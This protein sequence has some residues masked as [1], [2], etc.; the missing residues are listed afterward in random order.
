MSPKRRI[1][2]AFCAIFAMTLSAHAQTSVYR[3]MAAV[4]NFNDT[5]T[6]PNL[7]LV[8]N[9][10]WQGEFYFDAMSNRLKFAASNDF[11][12]EANQSPNFS[13]PVTGTA[14]RAG[15]DIIVTNTPP[16]LYRIT[17]NDSNLEYRVELLYAS[18][19]NMILNPS[20]EIQHGTRPD[21]AENWARDG[22]ARRSG[23]QSHSGSWKATIESSVSFWASQNSGA[24]PELTYQGSAWFW[25]D[26]TWTSSLI[27]LKIEFIGSGG[28]KVGEARTNFANV[29]GRWVKRTLRAVAP[30]GTVNVHLTVICEDPIPETLRFDDAE[31]RFI[32]TRNQDFDQWKYLYNFA[33]DGAHAWDDWMISTGKV[34]EDELR[35]LTASAS[36]PYSAGSTNFIRSALLTEGLG[37]ISF[38]YRHGATN[39]V[40]TA[41]VSFI[42]QKS[43]DN[44][45][46]TTLG[47]VT[48]IWTATYLQ[49]QSYQYDPTS[50]YVRIVHYGESTNRLL[51]DNI[52]IALP[53]AARRDQDF[54]NWSDWTNNSCYATGNWELCIGRINSVDSLNGKAAEIDYMPAG[55]NFL[56]S[57]QFNGI[58]T[59]SFWYRSGTNGASPV[60]FTL[61]ISTN[62]TVWETIDTVT[63]VSN[64]NYKYHSKYL[65]DTRNL[66]ARIRHD[67]GTNTLLIDNVYIA[68]PQLF[69]YQNFDT[70]PTENSY[71]TYQFQGWTVSNGLIDSEKAYKGK[72][73][74]LNF[75]PEI[76]QYIQSPYLPEGI[77][78]VRFYYSLWNTPTNVYYDIQLSQNG[79]TWTTNETIIVTSTNYTLYE[80][81]LYETNNHYVR[82]YHRS[83]EER[84]LFDEISVAELAPPADVTMY[85]AWHD[86]NPVFTNNSVKIWA[87]AYPWFGATGL[88]LT[89][90]YRIGTDGA[91][92][93]SSG[94]GLTDWYTYAMT[95]PIP[96]QNAGTTVQYYVQC[97]F[98]GLG[99]ISNTPKYYPEGGSTNPAS[100]RIPR[101]PQGRA[102][103]NEINYV[104]DWWD[105]STDTSEFVEIAGPAGW[106]LSGWIIKFYVNTTCYATYILPQGTFLSNT[107][108][109]YGFFVL[110]DAGV[111]N[112]NMLFCHTNVY[113]GT[114]ISDGDNA[115]GVQLCN[116]GGGIETNVCYGGP[117]QGFNWI[118]VIDDGET[119]LDPIDIQLSGTGTKYTNFVWSLA[120]MTPGAVNV[121]QCFGDCSNLSNAAVEIETIYCAATQITIMA[122]FTNAIGWVPDALYVT[123]LVPSP[124]TSDWILISP[125]QVTTNII[126]TD[127]GL[128][129]I[130]FAYPSDPLAQTNCYFRVKATKP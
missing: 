91:F 84:V 5:N 21:D 10:T 13:Q 114:Q 38:W 25:T 30:E 116:E 107:A 127:A 51:I 119:T 75:S 115:S 102:W 72:V 43:Y 95:N 90:H 68:A 2:I 49:Y 118:P 74:R 111:A 65:Y 42:V 121:D 88:T 98:G 71:G 120:N 26:T 57:P 32:A 39:D 87:L 28:G 7:M 112:V 61:Q 45:T 85:R 40:P 6:S 24:T 113:D 77:G 14:E 36:L 67:A 35:Y 18:G 104:N 126:S 97:D 129:S 22:N 37:S 55:N 17:L 130:Q 100:Y 12:G 106:D 4:G 58:G 50:C 20:F 11:F 66:Y 122:A 60:N 81:Y 109:G 78:S 94:M 52:D 54:N 73:A 124:Q 125:R 1:N 27:G 86:P 80:K 16:G 53:T 46:W 31:L 34:I 128:W 110:G 117:L 56:R 62:G 76:G 92:T 93:N 69:R 99:S 103:I 82:I 70:W 29:G 44:N 47:T 3:S 19:V 96:P 9:Y 108:S 41:P 33:N 63:N 101:N 8:S 59:I 23:G 105:K 123:K 64:T 83:G 79:T 89:A 48:N 15:G